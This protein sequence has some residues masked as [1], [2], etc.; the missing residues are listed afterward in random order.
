L[1]DRYHEDAEWIAPESELVPFSGNFYGKSGI[2]QFFAKLDAAVQ[3]IRFK[4][5]QF[6]AEGDTVVTGEGNWL[7]KP[8]GRH[9]DS[10][11][12]HVFTLRDG[13]VARFEGRFQEPTATLG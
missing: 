11:W 8:T 5:K 4:T 2:A 13:K 12:V 3:T 6:I 7:A 10:V 9:Y 1:L